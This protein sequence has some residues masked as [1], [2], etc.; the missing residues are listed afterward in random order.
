MTA[1]VTLICEHPKLRIARKPRSPRA[2]RVGAAT[3]S[4]PACGLLFEWATD[5]ADPLGPH[6]VPACPAGCHG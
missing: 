6:R 2:V 1:T 4:C 3:W 5:P